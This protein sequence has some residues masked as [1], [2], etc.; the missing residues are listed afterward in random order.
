MCIDAT[1]IARALSSETPMLLSDETTSVLNEQT[2]KEL[3][4][5]LRELT[6]KTVVTVMRWTVALEICDRNIEFQ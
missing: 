5:N 6:D 4:C 1:G 2:E 3:L